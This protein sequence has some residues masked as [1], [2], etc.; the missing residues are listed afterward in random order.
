MPNATA[1]EF[2]AAREPTGPPP[3]TLWMIL[4]GMK[5][6]PL[7]RWKTT[8]AEHGDVAHYR[9]LFDETYFV[10]HPDGVKRVLQDNAPNYTKD[11]GSY[12]ALRRLVGN[13]LLTSEGDFWLRQRRLAQPA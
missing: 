10:S 8:V 4:R 5:I 6:D 1:E 3:I 13:G 2:K 9:Y 11:H 7:Q 12:A